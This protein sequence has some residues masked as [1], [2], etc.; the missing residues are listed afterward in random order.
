MMY[1]E[2]GWNLVSFYFD[3]IN[4]DNFLNNDS[5]I[6]IKN[7][8]Q[9][10]NKKLPKELNSLNKLKLNSGYWINTSKST[11]VEVSG[12]LNKSSIEVELNKGWNLVNYPF[13]L[14]S[15]IKEIGLDNILEIKNNNET[16]NSTL[17]N[18]FNTLTTFKSNQGY[19]FNLSRKDRII[20]KYPF[21]HSQPTEN[22]TIK[23]L[24]GNNEIEVEDLSKIFEEDNFCIEINENSIVDLPWINGNDD[25][26]IDEMK[27]LIKKLNGVKFSI[28]YGSWN[29]E[30][31]SLGI[32]FHDEFQIFSKYSGDLII[33][34]SEYNDFN[35]F[36]ELKI[37]ERETDKIIFDIE[38]SIITVK[39]KNSYCFLKNINFQKINTNNTSDNFF[40]C[41]YNFEKINIDK[42]CIQKN[43]SILSLKSINYKYDIQKKYLQ[44]N[45][46][47]DNSIPI[48]LYIKKLFDKTKKVSL[49]MS[50]IDSK[51]E[52]EK[53]LILH[54]RTFDIKVKNDKFNINLAWSG[55]KNY[56]NKYVA[57]K[58]SE[59]SKYL[60]WYNL[61]NINLKS[62]EFNKKVVSYEIIDLSKDY[63]IFNINKD[64]SKYFVYIVKSMTY[65]GCIEISIKTQNN[66]NINM[67]NTIE[68]LHNNQ[69]I[70]I[71][72]YTLKLNWEGLLDNIG[73]QIKNVS[74]EFQ[75][76]I[77]NSLNSF[78]LFTHNSFTFKIHYFIGLDNNSINLNE[79]DSYYNYLD[80]LKKILS[81]CLDYILLLNL[82]LPLNDINLIKNGGGPS[83]D[84]YVLDKETKVIN[85]GDYY[86]TDNY[87]DKVTYLIL[88]N[89][90]SYGELKSKIF[91][92]IF[93]TIVASYNW[94]NEKWIS[95][96][97]SILFEYL[98]NDY[99]KI[100]LEKH[101]ELFKNKNLSISNIGNA[102]IDNDFYIQTKNTNNLN[103]INNK[104]CLYIDKI[105]TE[106]NEYDFNNN[107]IPN[108]ELKSS[109]DTSIVIDN[110]QIIND[111]NKNILQIELD[112]N[113]KVRFMKFKLY[114]NSE[115]VTNIKFTHEKR[116]K[117]SFIF[118]Y[119]L[120]GI[121]D[122][123]IFDRILKISQEFSHY[124][125]IENYINSVNSS[126]TFTQEL[127]DF[128][129]AVNISSN[130]DNINKKFRLG[131][132]EDIKSL[133][134]IDNESLVI[135]DFNN[136]YKLKYLEN[137]GS[138]CYNVIFDNTVK[139][140]IKFSGN[141]SV[142][143][144]H[145][146]IL[147]EY[148]DKQQ[149]VLEI[150][151]SN[152]IN[153]EINNSVEKVKLLIVA[154]KNFI[155]NEEITITTKNIITQ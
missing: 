35:K 91:Q 31:L 82:R 40:L 66:D 100:T 88:S 113:R 78:E 109:N 154:D 81:Y 112:S 38:D 16:F 63:L 21:R 110:I 3:D 25:I 74:D 126:S 98:I 8:N 132:S 130:S 83:Y 142:N 42:I 28:Y 79:W 56:I 133:I 139:G 124:N 120:L 5:I 58:F 138:K 116:G 84:I 37:G 99:S 2:K 70:Y 33:I 34:P 103:I 48:I 121:Y 92:N 129:T 97:L 108:L 144:L 147:I 90:L 125:C 155:D 149:K 61:K 12:I 9:Y 140:N 57:N 102:T 6:E 96:G 128:W 151:P 18:E 45:I 23:D 71:G 26:S 107:I 119:Y 24:V 27:E 53:I 49:D 73:Y 127:I 105:Y 60:Y 17:P 104:I 95:D 10:Y 19:W 75:R 94:N 101:F 14:K 4:F 11:V 32:N 47:D 43:N 59:N 44:I 117:S 106:Y 20:F 136:V 54:N 85:N 72:D 118:F 89:K 76:D 68:A 15:S 123:K 93:Y 30:I 145:K 146:R 131:N 135:N 141:F 7:L 77:G 51:V 46:I 52:N 137:T 143:K 122:N 64:N 22:S 114:C 1:L 115:L 86:N 55:P 80:I 87:L 67:I 13:K 150:E 62:I 153:I 41:D 39:Y 29:N 148:Y 152:D 50:S 111:K 134:N 36:V 69:I 65:Y